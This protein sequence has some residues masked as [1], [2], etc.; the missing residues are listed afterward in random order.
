MRIFLTGLSGY[1]GSMLAEHLAKLPE[2]ECIT[3]ISRSAP[4]NPLP[5][6][7]R[8]LSMDLRS[9]ELSSAIDGYDTIIHSAFIVL[10]PARIPVS[11]RDDINLNGIRN[12]AQA[13]V[14][15]GVERF[16]H[17][18]SIGAYDPIKLV[19]QVNGL[20]IS[21]FVKGIRTFIIAMGKGWLKNP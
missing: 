20:R 15:N 21:H 11:V 9:P 7:I 18:S 6:K 12:I 1:V 16:I 3:G 10:W 19:N 4:K 17:I 13:A 2:V 5:A 8:F 14:S